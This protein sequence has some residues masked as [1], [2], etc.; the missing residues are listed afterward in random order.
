MLAPEQTVSDF[1]LPAFDARALLR[2]LA[3]PALFAA[4]LVALLA[5]GGGPLHS[6]V[7]GLRR[8]LDVSPVWAIVAA[9]FE[10]VSL[11]GY[12]ILLSL[13]AGRVSPRIGTRESA[14]IT[15]AGA[16]ATRLLPT[17]GAG[18]AALTLWALKRSGLESRAAARTL[19]S[20]LVLLYS[21]F[22]AA[23]VV[24]GTAVAAG[25]F[26]HSGPV[27]LAAVPG[28]VALAAIALAVALSYRRDVGGAGRLRSAARLVA[29]AVRD[30]RLLVRR[31]DARL[32][33]AIA[34]W[35]FDAAV[36]WAMLHA[37]GA[38]TALPVVALAYFIGQV[39]NTVP[40]PGSVSS[41]MVGV[42]IAFAVPAAVAIPAV[43]AYRAVSVWLPSPVALAA[44]PRLRK[45]VARWKAEDATVA[46]GT[47]ACAQP[48]S[49]SSAGMSA[50][51]R[52]TI[53]T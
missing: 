16:A 17:A 11:A 47:G 43:L 19:L 12:V 8:G 41:G 28:A 45:T 35:A 1:A 32:A 37:F 52:P 21:V 25:L 24:S 34:Y 4:A 40:V 9:V 46:S 23:I 33:G 10:A 50:R 48:S 51:L 38:T 7:N 30:A 27:A 44:V 53:A 15:L 31:G 18:G 49:T 20:F 3:L 42:L 5:V 2:R 26:G 6:F 29:G 36:L 39:A 13:V 14:E 22:L